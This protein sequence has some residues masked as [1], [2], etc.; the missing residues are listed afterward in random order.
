MRNQAFFYVSFLYPLVFSIILSDI[1]F[2]TINA[3]Q[4][5]LSEQ[6][7]LNIIFD[8]EEKFM[9]LIYEGIVNGGALTQ[10]CEEWG[11]PYSKVMLWIRR[12]DDRQEMYTDALKDRNEW[13]RE[14]LLSELRKIALV[15]IRR[16][17]DEMG[18]VKEPKDWPKDVSAVIESFDVVDRYSKEGDLSGRTYKVKLWNKQKAIELLGKNM[19]MFIEQIKHSGSMTLEDLVAASI[20]VGEGDG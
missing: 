19:D 2:M 17:F 8:N 6:D 20:E 13:T 12:S 7:K 5:D 3:L 14:M 4:K 10:I 1:Y 16:L 11:V 18:S 15:D 9:G